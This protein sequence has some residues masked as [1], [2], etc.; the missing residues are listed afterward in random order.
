MSDVPYG[1]VLKTVHSPDDGGYYAEVSAHPLSG[2][3][4]W[5]PIAV[6]EATTDIRQTA[7]DAA[8]AGRRLIAETP[9]LNSGV[10]TLVLV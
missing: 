6:F 1:V 8:E 10:R 7:A 2:R 4:R 3:G 5:S 9:Q